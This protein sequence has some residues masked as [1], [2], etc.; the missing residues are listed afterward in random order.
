MD[1]DTVL[2]ARKKGK[3]IIFYLKGMNLTLENLV[4]VEICV[5]PE[6][7]KRDDSDDKYCWCDTD[8]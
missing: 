5:Q 4:D 2:V 6:R 8:V 1:F 7:S 3:D